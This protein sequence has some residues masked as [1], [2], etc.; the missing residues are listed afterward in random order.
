MSILIN[1]SLPSIYLHLGLI[2]DEEN[3]MMM[4]LNTNTAMNL[5]LYSTIF[6]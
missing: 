2:G 4:L 6:G 1:N 5:E 3:E